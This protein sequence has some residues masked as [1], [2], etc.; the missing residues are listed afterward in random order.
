M[1]LRVTG[2]PRPGLGIAARPSRRPQQRPIP[3]GMASAA[4]DPARNPVPAGTGVHVVRARFRPPM[5]EAAVLGAS[6]ALATELDLTP[7][8]PV[9][10]GE[11][12]VLLAKTAPGRFTCAT[13]AIGG[14]PGA[15]RVRAGCWLPLELRR[16]PRV[17]VSL[18][19][20]IRGARSLEMSANIENISTGGFLVV[21]SER[22]RGPDVTLLILLD[23]V[24]D[25]AP[26]R[27][28]GIRRQAGDYLLHLELD[29]CEDAMRARMEQILERQ[30]A[31]HPAQQWAEAPPLEHT[32]AHPQLQPETHR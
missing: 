28:V 5:V 23:D 14:A 8:V 6:S 7:V 22:P 13:I 15:I 25:Q 17:P 16:H 24:T 19:A 2:S 26:C 3:M 29:P 21:A 30:L 12:V 1:R 4:P 31:V 18:A 32:R 27:V 20:V 9:R 10:R 11:R